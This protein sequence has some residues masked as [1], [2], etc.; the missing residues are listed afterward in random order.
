MDVSKGLCTGKMV[1]SI[2]IVFLF[3][4]WFPISIGAVFAAPAIQ[5]EQ[6]IKT[7]ADLQFA[8]DHAE[9]GETIILSGD[10][11][12]GTEDTRLQLPEG[13]NLTLDLNGYIIDRNLGG[14]NDLRSTVLQIPESCIL[15]ICDHGEGTGIITGGYESNG[16]G[17]RNIGTLIL[18]GGCIIGNRA[19]ERGGGI[20]N[21]GILII[22]EG[23]TIEGN[24]AVLEG[25]GVYNTIL[26]SMTLQEN[27]VHDNQAPDQADICNNGTLLMP[28]GKTEKI[29]A[30]RDYLEYLSIIPVIALLLSLLFAIIIDS[31]LNRIQKKILY[32]IA[33]LIFLLILQNIMEYK[34]SLLNH[35]TWLR[36]VTA[37]TGYTL[38]P[39]ILVMF[40]YAVQPA[41]NFRPAWILLA[42]NTAVYITAF[43]SKIAFYFD[44]SNHFHAGL[45]NP[46]CMIISGAILINLI[47]QAIKVFH[48][49]KQKETWT[50]VFAV[51]LVA[52]SVVLDYTI[53]YYDEPVT[54]LT[55]AVVIS[56]ILYY[57]WL[58]LQFVREHENDLKAQQ[59]IQ[60]MKT[61]I[62][63]HFLY[64]TLMTIQALCLKDPEQAYEITGKFGLYLR[65]NLRT[66]DQSDLIPLRKELEHTK[67]YAEIEKMR[68]PNINVEYDITDDDFLLPPLTIQPIV[69]NAI[70]H[71]VRIREPGIVKISTR[72]KQHYHE[73]EISDNG[74][75]FHVQKAGFDEKNHIGISNV[76]E[77]IEKMC[78]GTLTIDS[79]ESIGTTVV[80]RIPES[81]KNI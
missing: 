68:F 42:A 32:I 55:I 37:V 12:A 35:G 18:E 7:W 16:G 6:E 64:N 61:Q 76:R 29:T 48:P 51:F 77:R 60:I 78:A 56:S 63:P 46:V 9:N 43:F 4:S 28:E 38:R 71:G 59:R 26:G 75:G 17:I 39:A 70:R 27:I 40:L 3:L 54:F 22:K 81:K 5:A 33:A 36:T 41:R 1:L 58:H 50:P 24:E 10:I 49:K 31:Y 14:Q 2:L 23:S 25:G 20:V 52:A 67:I 11:T 21:Y 79:K 44:D 34:L 74:I 15:T 65:Q 53:V 19:V 69:E 47:L 8:F 45:L 73:I 13:K 62:Q 30:I 80:I 66:L 57:I 72:N